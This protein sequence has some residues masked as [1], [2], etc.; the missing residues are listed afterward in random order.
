MVIIPNK[1]SHERA[2]RIALLNSRND[3]KES[4]I[5]KSDTH[6]DKLRGEINKVKERWRRKKIKKRRCTYVI[7]G[8]LRV[9]QC[10]YIRG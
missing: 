5:G 4:A 9:L 1:C 3:L 6:V 2:K 8:L 10:A 7:K